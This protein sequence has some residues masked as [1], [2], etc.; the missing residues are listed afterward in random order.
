M[1]QL[2]TLDSILRQN[3]P[4]ILTI[5]RAIAEATEESHK[6]STLRVNGLLDADACARLAQ[7]RGQRRRL[8]ENEKLDEVMDE[9]LKVQQAVLDGPDQLDAFDDDL[10]ESLVEKIVAESQTM[11]R[12]RL[13]GGLELTERLE[14]TAR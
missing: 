6:I 13:H 7:L 5:N 11:L 9:L 14:V 3:N 8:A 10:F 12:F 4:K 1:E 2:N